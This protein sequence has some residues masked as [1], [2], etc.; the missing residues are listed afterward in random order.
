MKANVCDRYR[1]YALLDHDYCNIMYGE[2][3]EVLKQKDTEGSPGVYPF[4]NKRKLGGPREIDGTAIIIHVSLGDTWVSPC[5]IVQY[6]R[7]KYDD[8]S[9]V[10]FIVLDCDECAKDDD[11][12]CELLSLIILYVT[13]TKNVGVVVI[14][15]ECRGY[16][17]FVVDF[18][19]KHFENT[20]RR[21]LRSVAA[22]H[23]IKNVSFKRLPIKSQCT[24]SCLDTQAGAICAIVNE[25]FANGLP[26]EVDF[27]GD[28]IRN[29]LKDIEIVL[30]V[31]LSRHVFDRRVKRRKG[32]ACLDVYEECFT[33]G[34]MNK[35]CTSCGA[36]LFPN[37]RQ[38]ACCNGGEVS[39]PVDVFDH[40]RDPLLKS[41]WETVLNDE[42]LFYMIRPLN[43]LLACAGVQL[44]LRSFPG[45]CAQRP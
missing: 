33:L 6:F 32:V 38:S 7:K 4:R 8:R 26:M 37:E 41:F 29:V 14:R 40:T 45:G 44:N 39:V 9:D 21:R 28:V 2:C 24:Y 5:L 17:G 10:R 20:L 42:H 22:E 19:T 3:G 43:N 15:K 13:M 34:E 12:T 31:S 36:L 35:V 18:V 23:G 11:C 16:H 25:Y 27:D 30:N 1:L